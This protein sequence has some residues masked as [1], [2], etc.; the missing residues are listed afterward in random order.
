MSTIP[1]T[2]EEVRE[3]YGEWSAMSIHLGSG[4]YTLPPAEDMR[5]RRIV[6][7][8]C[9]IL[10]KPISQLRVLDLACLEGHYAIEFAMHGA[11]AVGIELRE[12][13]LAKAIF[14]KNSLNLDQVTFFQDDVRNLGVEKY[15]LFDLVI[16]SGILYH[17]D[18]PDVFHFMKRIYEVCTRLVIFDT[19]IA[20]R[21]AETVKFEGR[22]YYGIRYKEHAANSDYE[23]RLRD[24]WASVNNESS[25]WLTAPSLANLVAD[26]GFSSFYEVLNPH[27]YAQ[28]DRRGYVAI[29]GTRSAILS[30]P[31]TD[32]MKDLAKPE[33][34]PP[35]VMQAERGPL[36]NLA[37]RALPQSVKDAIKPVLRAAHILP[38]DRTPK[39][40]RKEDSSNAS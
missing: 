30:S 34:A 3:R 23:A 2:I 6:Q 1:T 5:M 16:C 14:A 33:N 25:F 22:S 8:A 35:T 37:K 4:L 29:K 20:L 26:V 39:F 27:H 12:A 15:G 38:P 17:L 19:Q 40:L 11:S 31:V 21:P 24:L 18:E 7:I 32:G 9:D 28:E 10:Q 36:F 13:N